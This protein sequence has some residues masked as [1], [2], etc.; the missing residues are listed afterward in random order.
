MCYCLWYNYKVL[1]LKGEI[2]GMTI[3]D[4][5]YLYSAYADDTAFF[6]KDIISI[7]HMIGNF[8]FHTFP[9]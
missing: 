9:D 6:L 5:T 1:Q 4:Y 3:F 7:R 2:E 8:F